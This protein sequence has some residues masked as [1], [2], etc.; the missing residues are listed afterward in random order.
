MS[1]LKTLKEIP[2]PTR[3]KLE[4]ETDIIERWIIHFFN[5][6]ESELIKKEETQLCGNCTAC[7][8]CKND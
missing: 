7:G 1:E 6:K 3:L 5:I 8:F 2:Y 4:C